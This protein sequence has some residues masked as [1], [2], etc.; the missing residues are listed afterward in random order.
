MEDLKEI[1]FYTISDERIRRTSMDSQMKRGEIIITEYCNF[2]CSY[3]KGLSESVFADR[4]KKQMTLDEIKIVIDHWCH[5]IPLESIRF[6]GGEPTLHTNIMDIVSYAKISGIKNIAISTNGS[7]DLHVYKELIRLGVTDISISLDA[8]CAIDGDHMAGVTGS[9]D[10]VVNNIREISKLAYV[11]VGIVLTS[12]NVQKTIDT[13]IFA[14]SLGVADIRIISAAQYNKPIESLDKIPREILEKYP[15]LK[16]RS[17][18][19]KNG[20]NVRGMKETDYKHCALILDD[21]MVAGKFHYPCIIYFRERGKYIGLV[22]GNMR[23]ERK[24]WFEEHDCY[25]D[26]ICR[27]NCLDICRAFN[28]KYQD[29]HGTL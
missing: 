19:F 16:Y 26:D 28:L 13:I 18:N 4:R 15:I 29:F 23:E 10:I 24:K 5:K 8:C 1:G 6:S 12:E 9:F 22:G 7:N 27:N 20:D 17:D 21:S 11:T 14:D 3:C 2:R 25:A